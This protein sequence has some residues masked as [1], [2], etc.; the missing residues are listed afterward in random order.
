M[1]MVNMHEAKSQ[2]SGLV[3]DLRE[4]TEREIIICIAGRAVAKLVPITGVPP[5]Q[6]GVDRGLITIAP[7]FEDVNVEI[8]PLFE[9]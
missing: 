3:R 7:D 5:R 9:K 4:G 6:L 2:L 1:K 8:T